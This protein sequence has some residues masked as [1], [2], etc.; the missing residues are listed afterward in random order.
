MVRNG[1]D[2]GDSTSGGAL[3]VTVP[4]IVAPSRFWQIGEGT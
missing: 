2:I 4:G 3:G 1:G